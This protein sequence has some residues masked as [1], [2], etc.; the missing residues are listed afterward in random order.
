[1]DVFVSH[2]D[3]LYVPL[4]MLLGLIRLSNRAQLSVGPYIVEI[5]Q[6]LLDPT[7][8]RCSG[9]LRCRLVTMHCPMWY[10]VQQ[11][12]DTCDCWI[13]FLDMKQM[14]EPKKSSDEFVF[15]FIY[16]FAISELASQLFARTFVLAPVFSNIYLRFAFKV[17]HILT[18][19][20]CGFKKNYLSRKIVPENTP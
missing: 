18:R 15:I 12:E 8:G 5:Q 4:F 7:V 6:I 20:S 10:M 16:K 14:I 1:M 11:L 19:T 9:R 17:N 2:R 3:L 13:M